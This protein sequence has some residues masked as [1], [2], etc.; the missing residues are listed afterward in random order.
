[1]SQLFAA[2]SALGGHSKWLLSAHCTV[3]YVLAAILA[4]PAAALGQG[5]APY[6]GDT[7]ASVLTVVLEWGTFLFIYGFIRRGGLNPLMGRLCPWRVWDGTWWNANWARGLA[8]LF[9]RRSKADATVV[10]GRVCDACTDEA[11]IS[12][13]S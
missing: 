11:V 6:I 7:W 5:L 13:R 4:L 12:E 1:M 2:I 10:A 3:A 8:R 9:K